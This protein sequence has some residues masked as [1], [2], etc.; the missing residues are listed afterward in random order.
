MKRLAYITQ[1]QS[2]FE[3]R[4]R[5]LLDSTGIDPEEFIGLEYF[6]LTPFF[7][8]SGANVLADAHTH[9][10]DV[11]VAGVYVEVAPELEDAFYAT[12]PKILDD[13][14]GEPDDDGASPNGA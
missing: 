3:P 6:S 9:G 10:D 5:E 13:A 14:Y 1:G 11:H 4:L 2:E 7:V 8:I 12:L